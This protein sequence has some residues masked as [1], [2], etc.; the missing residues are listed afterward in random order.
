M[1]VIQSYCLA[2]LHEL[3]VEYVCKY[4]KEIITEDGKK[5]LESEPICLT[6][7]T[8]WDYPMVSE[9]SALTSDFAEEYMQK[10]VYGYD[11]N[12]NFEYD[13]HSRLFAY[14][15]I[16]N[17]IDEYIIPKLI[18]E[19]ESRRAIAITWNPETDETMNDCPCL[20]LI[21]CTVRDKKLD[22]TAVFRSNDML[23]AAG[24]NMYALVG[25]QSYIAEKVGV[26]LGKYTHISLI[27]HIYYVDDADELKKFVK[28]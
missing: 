13:Y 25:L 7:T 28:K 21:Q 27:P 18:S 15:N 14:R 9:K 8:P 12:V 23:L 17:Q 26:T 6:T 1:K 19:P 16:V 5:T 11:K 3:A 20:Q 24:Q 2:K 4:G 10:L 22:I